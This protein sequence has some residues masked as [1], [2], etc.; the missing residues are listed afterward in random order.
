MGGQ[1]GHIAGGLVS[2]PERG[3][4]L[5]S[6]SLSPSHRIKSLEVP[7]LNE[8]QTNELWDFIKD[9]P[10]TMMTTIDGGIIRSRPMHM[11][12][13]NFSGK[14]WF[15]TDLSAAKS[16]EIANMHEVGLS[17]ED[18]HKQRYVSLSGTARTIRDKA[19][20]EQFWN[21]MVGAWFPNGKDDSNIG[22][23]EVTAHQA[24]VWDATTGR[25][26]QLFKIALAN[27]RNQ[28]PDVG[29]HHRYGGH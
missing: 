7:V 19:L 8:D 14:L 17:Y 22:F 27:I 3:V 26:R 29:E 5:A 25:V 9:I 28:K 13:K 15:F 23:I 6:F 10:V 11:V 4:N 21:S 2:G 18:T 16:D 12:Q 20:V 1:P 24:E